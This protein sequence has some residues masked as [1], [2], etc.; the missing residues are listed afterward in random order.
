MGIAVKF[1]YRGRF[2][3][4]WVIFYNGGEET[5][6]EGVDPDKWCFFELTGILETDL[7][8]KKPFRLWW[9]LDEEVSFRVIKDESIDVVDFPNYDVVGEELRESYQVVNNEK[10]QSSEAVKIDKGK[11]VLVYNDNEQ[12]DVGGISIVKMKMKMIMIG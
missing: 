4:D 3:R 11:G 2:V 9:M 8:V 7:L 6:I 10:G 1:H 12:G 5:L